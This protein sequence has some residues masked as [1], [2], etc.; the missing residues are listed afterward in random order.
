[1]NIV[2]LNYFDEIVNV[3]VQLDSRLVVL[4]VLYLMNI[5]HVLCPVTA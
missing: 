5:A 4:E 2:A 1:M 3:T